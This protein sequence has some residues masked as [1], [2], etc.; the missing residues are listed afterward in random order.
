MRIRHIH[1]GLRKRRK[2]AS[3]KKSMAFVFWPGRGA[4]L[5][6]EPGAW[7]TDIPGWDSPDKLGQDRKGPVMAE[8]TR[9]PGGA[10]LLQ[11]SRRSL[12]EH[13]KPPWRREPLSS[14]QL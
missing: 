2:L 9:D 7:Q 6:G 11:E 12:Q 8:T 10:S 13:V 4:R 5:A 3:V 14:G 1:A